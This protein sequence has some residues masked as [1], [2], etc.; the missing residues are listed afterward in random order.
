[1]GATPRLGHAAAEVTLACRRSSSSTHRAAVH[2]NVADFVLELPPRRKFMR[3]LQ[4]V[5]REAA[6]QR[7]NKHLCGGATVLCQTRPSRPQRR[8]PLLRTDRT[9]SF[10]ITCLASTRTANFVPSSEAKESM[11]ESVPVREHAESPNPIR[12]IKGALLAQH[13]P[14][15]TAAL[16]LP[17]FPL[18]ERLSMR[19]RRENDGPRQ[20]LQEAKGKRWVQAA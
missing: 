8:L 16:T 13:V 12:T 14:P 1:M 6:R 3:R 11:G 17:T 18:P 10:L 4:G 5:S 7:R 15:L 9:W 19:T 20:T 2:Q